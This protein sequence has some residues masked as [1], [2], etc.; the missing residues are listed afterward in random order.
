MN[1]LLNNY[2]KEGQDPKY[3]LMKSYNFKDM[4][5]YH[6]NYPKKENK[7]DNYC[8]ERINYFEIF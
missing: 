3:F 6:S 1:T 8:N 4:I 2:L 5:K 7:L